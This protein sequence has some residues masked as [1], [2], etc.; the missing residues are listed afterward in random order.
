MLTCLMVKSILC[1]FECLRLETVSKTVSNSFVWVS[2]G[3][4][5]VDRL[6]GIR[7]HMR[8]IN[9]IELVTK[10][11]ESNY[12]LNYF[13][14]RKRKLIIVVTIYRRKW[15]FTSLIAKIKKSLGKSLKPSS[16]TKKIWA[17]NTEIPHFVTQFLTEIT[18]PHQP[19]CHSIYF[20]GKS[21]RTFRAQTLFETLFV[22]NDFRWLSHQYLPKNK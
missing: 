11:M 9:W 7:G 15:K 21:L 17:I 1:S 22:S 19:I 13:I 4:V 3:Y 6:K 8:L 14:L 10:V 5:I 16:K 18:P 2:D 12:F 20:Q